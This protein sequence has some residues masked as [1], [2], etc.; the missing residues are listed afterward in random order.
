MFGSR[1]FKRAG[2]VLN[3]DCGVFWVTVLGTNYRRPLPFQCNA[4]ETPSRLSLCRVC[5]APILSRSMRTSGRR[6]EGV[7]RAFSAPAYFLNCL[8][9]ILPPLRN[10]FNVVAICLVPGFIFRRERR[11][12][13]GSGDGETKHFRFIAGT[14]SVSR[15]RRR[16]KDDSPRRRI[17]VHLSAKDI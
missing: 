7:G 8:E 13:S 17:G 6:C 14:R 1:C 3:S 10:V 5:P 11:E 9:P 12:A 15:W 4:P 16:G 2:G